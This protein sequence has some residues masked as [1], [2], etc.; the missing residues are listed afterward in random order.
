MRSGL[1]SYKFFVSL[2]SY[3]VTKSIIR[4]M[5]YRQPN[6]GEQDVLYDHFRKYGPSVRDLFSLYKG[7]RTAKEL[8][9]AI[10]TVLHYIDMDKLQILVMMASGDAL[11]S[12][13]LSRPHEED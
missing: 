8:D 2:L 13:R 6:E 10:K 1:G 11:I 3:A 7:T 4:A 5:L 9:N 12:D